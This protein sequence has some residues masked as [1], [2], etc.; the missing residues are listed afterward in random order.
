MLR[1]H[2]LSEKE[3]G[4]VLLF[5]PFKVSVSHLTSIFPSCS[6]I[7][8]L[9]DRLHLVAQ[10]QHS[11]GNEFSRNPSYPNGYPTVCDVPKL[12]IIKAKGNILSSFF[13][14]LSQLVENFLWRCKE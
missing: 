12:N 14:F 11:M 9:I 2:S 5:T 6:T 3:N 1:R 10:Q 7:D 8:V 4:L 13:F